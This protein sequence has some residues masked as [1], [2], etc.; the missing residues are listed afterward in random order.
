MLHDRKYHP[1]VTQRI[2]T[3]NIP[4][5]NCLH[6]ASNFLQFAITS[7]VEFAFAH[8][9]ASSRR[10]RREGGRTRTPW[11][12]VGTRGA[13]LIMEASETA[14]SGASSCDSQLM[15]DLARRERRRFQD[16]Q[17]DRSKR[18]HPSGS[19]KRKQAKLSAAETSVNPTAAQNVV[20]T[21]AQYPTLNAISPGLSE[22]L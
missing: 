11:S 18:K 16:Q 22:V 7:Y 4:T 17:R 20:Q 6:H 8:F 5:A 10:A 19:A 12:S 3:E 2:P 15:V 21:A 14:A 1:T 9:V 13:R